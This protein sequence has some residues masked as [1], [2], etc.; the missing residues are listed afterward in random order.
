MC[1]TGQ[2]GFE[3][4][5][6]VSMAIFYNDSST[7]PTGEERSEAHKKQ[8]EDADVSPMAR[9]R[10]AQHRKPRAVAAERK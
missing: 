2:E 4:S 1:H 8:S 6:K 9:V 7:T 3:R 10:K 5:V